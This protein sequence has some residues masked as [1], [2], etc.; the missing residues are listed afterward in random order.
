MILS[1]RLSLV[2]VSW[3]T[4]ISL[5]FNRHMFDHP[6]LPLMLPQVSKRLTRRIKRM[7]DKGQYG[8]VLIG[9]H[10]YIDLLDRSAEVDLTS[11]SFAFFSRELVH[12]PDALIKTLL[13]HT[14]PKAQALGSDLLAAYIRSQVWVESC[15][16]PI[17]NLLTVAI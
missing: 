1:L 2:R 11:Y 16:D 10:A 3:V 8:M 9:V 6:V 14:N 15:D 12:P 4:M 5:D 17:L 7:L 13:M